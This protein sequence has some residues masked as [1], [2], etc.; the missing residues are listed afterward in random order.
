M[1]RTFNLCALLHDTRRP[2]R[3]RRQEAASLRSTETLPSS[4][5]NTRNSSNRVFTDDEPPRARLVKRIPPRVTFVT[6]RGTMYTHTNA[7]ALPSPA[8][9]T[10]QLL[11]VSCR[12]AIY[13]TRGHL[14]KEIRFI[15]F[16]FCPHIGSSGKRSRRVS[17]DKMNIRG[18]GEEPLL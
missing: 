18:A 16:Y 4:P 15:R 12:D 1:Q 9:A 11:V 8:V 13:A 17:R 6:G 7:A 14:N 5:G 2:F 3:S 10:T